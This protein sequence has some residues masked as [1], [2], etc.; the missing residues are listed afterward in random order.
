VLLALLV[1]MLDSDNSKEL[2]L[3][4]SFTSNICFADLEPGEP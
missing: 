1:F 4:V 3:C 2:S